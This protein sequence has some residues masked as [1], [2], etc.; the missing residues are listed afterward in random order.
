MQLKP[1]T[2]DDSHLD[3][4]LI[5]MINVVFL[6]LIFFMVAGTFK[7]VAPVEIDIP[8]SPR[9]QSTNLQRIIS[10]DEDAKIYI[11]NINYSISEA[12]KEIVSNGWHLDQSDDLPLTLNVDKNISMANF[13]NIVTMIR[14]SGIT[15]VELLTD[16]SNNLSASND[17]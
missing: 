16:Y 5:P 15:Q 2:N 9:T 13:K 11:D 14:Q 6:L 17:K 12:G 4:S 1:N 8:D 7:L 3:N 10:V